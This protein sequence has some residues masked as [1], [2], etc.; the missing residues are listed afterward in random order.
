MRAQAQTI[1]KGGRTARGRAVHRRVVHAWWMPGP[2]ADG[3]AAGGRGLHRVATRARAA[4]WM[5]AALL[6]ATAPAASA[7][8]TCSPASPYPAAPAEPLHAWHGFLR[9]PTRLA[10]DGDDNVYVADPLHGRIAVRAADGRIVEDLQGF[11]YPVSLAVDAAG[12]LYVGEGRDGR[13]DV[14]GP[15][16]ARERVAALGQGDGEF[17]LPAHV[18]V[19]DGAAGPRVFVSDAHADEVLAYD[20]A[21]GARLLVIGGTGS[22]PGRF[23]FPSGLAVAAGELYVVDRG[24][25]RLQVFGVDGALHRV[26]APPVDSCGFLCA[27]EGATRGRARD[28]GVHVTADGVI[29]LAESSKG[30]VLA[31][32]AD[33]TGLGVVGRFGTAPG[34]LRVASDVVVDSCGRVLV[35]SAA[36]GRVELFGLPGHGDPEAFAPARLA[37]EGGALDPAADPLLVARL[38]IPGHRLGEITDLTANGFA[39]PLALVE[40]DADRDAQPDLTITFGPDLVRALAGAGEAV[41]TVT[42]RVGALGF[43]ASAGVELRVT[44]ADGDG[45]D[46]PLDACAHTPPG[47]AVDAAGCA[48]AQRCPCETRPDGEPWRNHGRYVSCV[49][50]AA[51][52]LLRE[53]AIARGERRD[54]VRAAAHSACGAK[55]RRARHARDDDYRHRAGHRARHRDGKDASRRGGDGSGGAHDDDRGRARDRDDDRRAGRDS[56]HGTPPVAMRAAASPHGVHVDGRS[57]RR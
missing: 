5:A 42:G 49:V 4:S 55:P 39:L 2:R 28:A 13:V 20:G 38:A 29:W 12:R 44:D 57:V 3:H 16:P 17:G 23:V 7:A 1:A 31:I 15:A 41:V 52:R 9:A 53:G 32:G 54:L 33:G 50:H 35:A 22:A 51:G 11:D 27:F 48:V 8:P 21:S 18:A 26:V 25:S 37:V 14:Y 34:R 45:I 40:G 43:E 56:E 47:V 10:I 6:L 36:N 19:H 46:D 24:N 30:Q